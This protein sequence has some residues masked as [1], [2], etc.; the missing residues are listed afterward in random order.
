MQ[1]HM[2]IDRIKALCTAR[3]WTYYR[4]AKESGMAYST[5]FTMLNKANE[6]SISTLQ[7]ICDGFGITMAQFFEED[8]IFLYMT[9]ADKAHLRHWMA[10][11][12]ENK[13]A[14]EK[15]TQFLLSEQSAE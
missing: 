15:Y 2:V 7:K 12:D 13:P 11:S 8:E 9:A 5:L 4:L 6:P 14:I 3:S 1:E 10:L